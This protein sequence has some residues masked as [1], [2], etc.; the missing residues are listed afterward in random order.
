[1]AEMMH[2]F[3]QRSCKVHFLHSVQ[4]NPS[5]NPQ[6]RCS[7]EEGKS[8]K[9]RGHYANQ[10]IAE[11]SQA[12][13][14]TLCE[15]K[16][17]VIELHDQ[18]N[19]PIDAYCDRDSHEEEGDRGQGHVRRDGEEA[20]RRFPH[21]RQAQAQPPVG[22]RGTSRDTGGGRLGGSRGGPRGFRFGLLLQV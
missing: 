8:P 12:R 7:A 1:M 4:E 11:A 19:D 14:A 3:R 22:A 9:Q 2:H 17:D 13:S 6:H 5:A 20:L 15:V 18:G 21:L 10:C 16:A